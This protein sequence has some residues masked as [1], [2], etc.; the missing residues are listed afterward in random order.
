LNG[1]NSPVNDRDQISIF[2]AMAGGH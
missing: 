2:P 1:A